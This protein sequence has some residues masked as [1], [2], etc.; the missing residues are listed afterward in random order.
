MPSGV[1]GEHGLTRSLSLR[2]W[3]GNARQIGDG[4]SLQRRWTP[5]S[6]QSVAR[7]H[8]R[9]QTLLELLR[10]DSCAGAPR[11]VEPLMGRAVTLSLGILGA[12]LFV[13]TSGTAADDL[14]TVITKTSSSHDPIM[15]FPAGFDLVSGNEQPP[16]LAGYTISNLIVLAT[17]WPPERVAAQEEVPPPVRRPPPPKLR[18]TIKASPAAQPQKEVGW[19]SADWWRGLTWIRIR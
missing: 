12:V 5:S 8:G 6:S 18:P 19:L 10:F 17:P 13:A 11:G 1:P 14:G 2:M 4:F 3:D 9:S 7:F 16:G 15:R